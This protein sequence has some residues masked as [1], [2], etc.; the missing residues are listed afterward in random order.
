MLEPKK[1]VLLLNLVDMVWSVTFLLNT[2]QVMELDGDDRTKDPF[3]F[4]DDS[5]DPTEQVP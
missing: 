1:F 3:D 4:E 2:S 5:F